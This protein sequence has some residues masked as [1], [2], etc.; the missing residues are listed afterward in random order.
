M[1]FVDAALDLAARGFPV[2]PCL[3]QAK[4]PA[5]RRGFHAATTNPQ[6]IRRL[7]LVADRNIG[8]ATGMA[9]GVWITDVDDEDGEANLRRLEA[10]H[11]ALPQTW[12]SLTA[13]GRHMYFKYPQQPVRNT[14][15]KIA[16]GIDT[17]G[18]GGYA[19][20]PPS[21]HPTGRRYCWS[22]D[23]ANQFADAPQWLL[24]K[25]TAPAN[26]HNAM[27]AADWRALVQSTISEGARDCTATKLTGYL[28]RR[29]IDPVVALE[30]LQS[31]NATR[32]TP[33]LPAADI[34]RIVASIAEKE[35]KRRQA[36]H[37]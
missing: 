9:S 12:E 5:V 3:P 33:P 31:W 15:G 4:E 1:N 10:E 30:L 36:G 29:F 11:G 25:I 24:D 23:S 35:K 18:D 19:L 28:L 20:V 27:P 8:I 6:T 34:E 17:R 14:A 26:G 16:P 32:C 21:M 7:W 37:G 2:F 13:R 22:V